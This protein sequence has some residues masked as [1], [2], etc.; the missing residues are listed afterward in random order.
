MANRW[1]TME[2]GKNKTDFIFLVSKITADSSCNHE[3]KRSLLLER[4]AMTNLVQFTCSVMSN[5]VT[6]WTAA[7][8]ASLFNTNSLSLLK[9]MSME[10]V[11]LSNHLILC[12]PLL[13]CLQSFPASGSFPVSQ[14]FVSGGQSIGVSVSASVLPVN[15]QDWFPLALTG[16]ISLQSKG[17]LR[18]FSNTP[19]QKHQF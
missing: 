9:L 14:F 13:S 19:V 8:Q 3:I 7:C 10:S 15:I 17:L 16:L 11:M 4:K 12:G 1:K 6:P 2:T 18:V 5:S